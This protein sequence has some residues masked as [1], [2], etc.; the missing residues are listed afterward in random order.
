MS[1]PDGEARH[2]PAVIAHRNTR[3]TDVQLRIADAITKFAGSM[4]FVYIHAVGFTLWM[5]FVESNPW[6]T[7]TLVVSLE[8]IFLSTFVMI[9]QNRQAAFQQIKADHDFVE[10]ELELKTNTELT[11][12]I[13]AMTTELH[14]R[15]ISDGNEQ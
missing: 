11:R 2:H 9:G 12:A 6:P 13:H 5:L 3:A 4:R 10:Q 8:A 1:Q 15:L 14:S 7:L